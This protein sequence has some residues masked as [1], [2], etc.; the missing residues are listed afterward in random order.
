MRPRTLLT[1]FVGVLLIF[2]MAYGAFRFF[3]PTGF[4]FGS[5]PPSGDMLDF[6]V[7]NAGGDETKHIYTR[8]SQASYL[9]EPGDNIEYDVRLLEE[10][11]GAGG[12]EIFTQDGASFR[13]E[14]GWEDQNG[15]SGNPATDLSARAYRKWYHRKLPVPPVLFAREAVQWALAGE[16]DGSLMNYRAQYANLVVTGEKGMVKKTIFTAGSDFQL[17]RSSCDRICQCQL[18]F[19]QPRS[20]GW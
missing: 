5:K 12:I 1:S 15:L 8:I 17:G 2:L 11:A 3:L 20:P 9:F 13:N 18:R 4:L 19:S 16:N 6:F 7:Y 14:A 10:I